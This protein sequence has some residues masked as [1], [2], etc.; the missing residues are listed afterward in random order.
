MAYSEVDIEEHPEMGA[1]LE[2]WTGGFRTVPT[3][4][5]DGRIL[6]NPNRSELE[7]AVRG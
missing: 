1:Q 7:Q 4:D 3:F 6:V 2:Q 5:V